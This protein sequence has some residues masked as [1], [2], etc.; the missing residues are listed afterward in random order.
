MTSDAL[1]DPAF[2]HELE[3]LRRQLTVRARS[4]RAGEH[5]TRRRGGAAEF[6]E[7]RAY[8]AGDDLRRMDW[9][10]FAR[11]GSPVLKV[12]HAEE[13]TLVRLVVDRS[14]SLDVGTPTKLATAK[15]LAASIGYMAL[16]SSERAQV[17]AAGEA[18]DASYEPG[19][20]RASLPRVLRE[21]SGLEAAGKTDLARVV[22]A[23]V[24]RA[25]RPGML[26]VVSDFLDP[27]PF[28]VA[29]AR[30]ASAGHHIALVQVLADDELE[31]PYEGDFAFEDAETGEVV[32]VTVDDRSR[33]AYLARL[34]GLFA[35]LRALAKRH[36]GTY[37][38]TSSAAAILEP[39]R[40]FA[41]GG[42]D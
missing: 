37:V 39:L 13:D 32:L 7:H 28:D 11:T 14:A 21:L 38:R 5:A 9:L 33:G 6:A 2:V 3:A 20:G 23:I 24:K 12:F 17:H 10:A 18:L 19:R 42:V 34:E 4:G 27:G 41:S 22:D 26:V 8:G 25:P 16:A 29:L 1:L 35:K 15:R 40:R 36:R 31:P 30:A